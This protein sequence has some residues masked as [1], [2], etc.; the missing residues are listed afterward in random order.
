M[1]LKRM[2]LSTLRQPKDPRN[3]SA[4][5]AESEPGRSAFCSCRLET[6]MLLALGHDADGQ[7]AYYLAVLGSWRP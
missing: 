4:V 1:P 7:L 6:E 5:K 2:S 3:I